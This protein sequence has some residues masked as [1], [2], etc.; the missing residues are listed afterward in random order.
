MKR[1]LVLAGG[2][3][4]GSFQAGVW[5]YLVQIG[6]EPDIICGT[7]IGAINAA[8]IGSGMDVNTIIH[9]WTTYNRRRMYRLNLLQF[10][11]YLFSKRAI[12]PLLDT[13]PLKKILHD[14]L[15]FTALKK[16]KT[17]III[18][19]VNM[20]TG[21][22]EF[23]N[24]SQIQ[25]EHILASSAMPLL[26]PWQEINGEPYW[27]GG[28]MVNTPIAPALDFGADEII[29]VLL[30]PVSHKKLTQPDT[31][32]KAGEH[33]FEHLLAGSYQ[34]NLMNSK[35]K[36]NFQP[37]IITLAPSKM[38]GF[39]S[40]LNFSKAQANQLVEEGY[41]TAGR[42]LKNKLFNAKE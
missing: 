38:L 17:K 30:S 14:N 15:D 8:G 25:L 7:S 41:N 42:E 19:A 31:V 40:L 20:L 24:Q 6:W 27:D 36:T 18:T 2:G 16:S 21:H 29:V 22:P 23:F 33:L 34:A 5:K 13:K 26:F 4:R 35:I 32:L 37:K 3:A 12:K 11:A 1:A 9:L 28:V 10:A 39:R